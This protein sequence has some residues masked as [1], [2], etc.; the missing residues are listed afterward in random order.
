MDWNN[1]LRA[2]AFPLVGLILSLMKVACVPVLQPTVPQRVDRDLP[3]VTSFF[4]V[5]VFFH[6]NSY[7]WNV[8]RYSQVI[9]AYHLCGHICTFELC[10]VMICFDPSCKTMRFTA[11]SLW[12]TLESGSSAWFEVERELCVVNAI[13]CPG[14]S[15]V[16]WM[17]RNL[18]DFLVKS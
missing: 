16:F 7:V 11:C 15:L 8:G 18:C 14:A 1:I 13:A 3:C 10:I 2:F 4:L 6:S 9:W 12:I 17:D 5:H